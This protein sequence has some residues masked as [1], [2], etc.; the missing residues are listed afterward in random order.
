MFQNCKST[1]SAILWGWVRPLVILPAMDQATSSQKQAKNCSTTQGSLSHITNLEKARDSIPE[2][3]VGTIHGSNG[4]TYRSPHSHTCHH[5]RQ[6]I[7]PRHPPPPPPSPP[8][9]PPFLTTSCSGFHT[10]SAHSSA[11]RTMGSAFFLQR[12]G[13]KWNSQIASQTEN[14]ERPNAAQTYSSKCL[15]IKRTRQ[16]W[17]AGEQE[18]WRWCPNLSLQQRRKTWSGCISNVDGWNTTQSQQWR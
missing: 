17:I 13:R 3:L 7:I 9:T 2:S 10:S 16:R 14:R 8:P 6:A 18:R 12:R 1:N 11:P 5:P 15:R 4:P